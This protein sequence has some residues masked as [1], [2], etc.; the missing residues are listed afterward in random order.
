MELADVSD[1][2]LAVFIS[3]PRYSVMLL[4]PE[5]MRTNAECPKPHLNRRL[6]PF[7]LQPDK[8][9]EERLRGIP[10]RIRSSITLKR[11]LH[12]KRRH[13]PANH[14]HNIQKHTR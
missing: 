9:L 8:Q 5:T 10:R 7:R 4:L 14:P 3:Y 11:R 12:I 2:G 13:Q 1:S 6:H